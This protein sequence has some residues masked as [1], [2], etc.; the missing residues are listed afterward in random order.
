[1]ADYRSV[2]S[3]TIVIL[4]AKLSQA[5]RRSM[6]SQGRRHDLTPTQ[7]RTLIFLSEAAADRC[8]VSTL[9]RSQGVSLP[10]AGG[11]IDALVHRKLVV[12]VPNPR[13][14]RSYLLQL[15]V[16]GEKIRREIAAW[17]ATVRRI[18]EALPGERQE[19]LL[20][21]LRHV[22][23]SLRRASDQSG[24]KVCFACRYFRPNVRTEGAMIH[25][26]ELLDQPLSAGDAS[27]EC[28]RHVAA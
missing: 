11:I 1:M 27:R 4:L 25:H 26:C 3:E 8:T 9:A 6:W 16:E 10:T 28:P 14:K 22:V 24:E 15:T 2:A 19:I 21:S 23:G 17:E 20:E 5:L 13:D 7:V 18:I 12:R